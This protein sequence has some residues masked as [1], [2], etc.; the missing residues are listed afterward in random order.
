M[1]S[2][3]QDLFVIGDFVC[4]WNTTNMCASSTAPQSPLVIGLC[5]TVDGFAIVWL[6]SDGQVA[7]CCCH[8]VPK[9]YYE[10]I[11][12]DSQRT[13]PCVQVWPELKS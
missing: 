3:I 4:K 13:A 11:S 10:K 8:V 2:P 6:A 12:L 9:K 1:V 7:S 5:L